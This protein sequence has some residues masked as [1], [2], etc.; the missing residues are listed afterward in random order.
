MTSHL[1]RSESSRSATDTVKL[2]LSSETH[3]IHSMSVNSQVVSTAI[4]ASCGR[5]TLS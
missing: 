5:H 2:V 1:T 3:R 4:C